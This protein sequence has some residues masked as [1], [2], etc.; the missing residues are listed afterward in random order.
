MNTSARDRNAVNKITSVKTPPAHPGEHLGYELFRRG[1]SQS[2]A[3]R[4]LAVNPAVIGRSVR[5]INPLST[6]LAHRLE[7]AGVG[8]AAE[9]LAWQAEY[10]LYRVSFLNF[11]DV[12]PFPP[13]F[14]VA[15]E[16]VYTGNDSE[17]QE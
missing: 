10:D 15:P 9:W 6:S 11:S 7:L 13:P 1:L 8:K 2:D 5:G 4:L 12:Q 14:V 3:A 16:P 17:A